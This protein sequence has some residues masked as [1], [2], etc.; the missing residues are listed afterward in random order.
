ML[1]TSIIFS[2]FCIALLQ[3]SCGGTRLID[4]ENP[5]PGESVR[6]Q[7]KDGSEKEGILIAKEGLV[8]KYVDALSHN[9]IGL[10]MEKINSLQRSSHIYDME[11]NTISEEQIHEAKGSGKTIGYSF[12]GVALGAAVG[13]GVGVLIASG[14]DIPIGYSMAA[15]GLAGGIALGIH[16]SHSD[17]ADA[18]DKI[19]QERLTSANAELR[20]QLI[21]EQKMLEEQKKAK[22]KMIQELDQKKK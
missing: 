22:E 5:N 9:L 15:F 1:K 7:F 16:G 21:Q 19:R 14:S 13:F 18:I 17:R 10:E 8:I 11:G 2:I 20:E 6:I 4:M 12:A 3:I